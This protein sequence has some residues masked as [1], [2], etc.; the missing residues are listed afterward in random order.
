MCISYNVVQ[1]C[2]AKGSQIMH[3]DVTVYADSIPKDL[4]DK[5]PTLVEVAD[6]VRASSLNSVTNIKSA[7]GTTFR[8][9]SK[10]GKYGKGWYFGNLLFPTCV[11][12]PSFV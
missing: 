6:G 10:R 7:G 5:Y 4:A 8:V 11:L 3:N 1:T 9:F 12:K 2:I